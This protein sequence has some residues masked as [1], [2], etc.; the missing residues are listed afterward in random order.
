MCVGIQSLCPMEFE[1]MFLIAWLG[2]SGIV[3]A[4]WMYEFSE[5]GEMITC[6]VVDDGVMSVKILALILEFLGVVYRVDRDGVEDTCACGEAG[7]ARVGEW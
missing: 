4:A 2:F 3:C 5:Q 7:E 6:R 1:H